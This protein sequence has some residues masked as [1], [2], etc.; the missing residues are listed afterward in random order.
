MG[1]VSSISSS[2]LPCS[3]PASFFSLLSPPFLFIL[4]SASLCTLISPSCSFSIPSAYSKSWTNKQAAGDLRLPSIIQASRTTARNVCQTHE[5]HLSQRERKVCF[6]IMAWTRYTESFPPLDWEIRIMFVAF[7]LCFDRKHD[8]ERQRSDVLSADETVP[9][10]WKKQDI[11]LLLIKTCLVPE[12]TTW[13]I[14]TEYVRLYFLFER[15]WWFISSLLW[16]NL[17]TLMQLCYSYPSQR[18]QRIPPE[19]QPNHLW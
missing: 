10:N 9:F 5:V 6:I 18:K 15:N 19:T 7:L 16:L 3:H 17:R 11:L 4:H 8:D 13:R 14:W 1:S 2:C 12:R